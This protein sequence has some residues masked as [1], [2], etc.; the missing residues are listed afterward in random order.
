MLLLFAHAARPIHAVEQAVGARQALLQCVQQ[1]KLGIGPC[2]KGSARWQ[3]W[4]QADHVNLFQQQWVS[5][6]IKNNSKRPN[7]HGG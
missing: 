4:D 1:G 5:A 3:G 6:L 2:A 7:I